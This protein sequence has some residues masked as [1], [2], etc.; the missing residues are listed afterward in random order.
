MPF[1]INTFKIRATSALI[2]GIIMLAALLAGPSLFFVIF[3]AITFLCAKEY[4]TIM[5]T[6]SK[7]NLSDSVQLI[8]AIGAAIFF[9]AIAQSGKF[10]F[11]TQINIAVNENIFLGITLLLILYWMAMM[12][13]GKMILPLI[14]GYLYIS[15]SFGLLALAYTKFN[16]LPLYLIVLIWVNDTMQY[17]VGSL[18][19]KTKMAPII[20]PK[21]TWEGTIGGSLLSITAAIVWGY[22]S[23]NYPLPLWIGLGIIASAI[24]T[25][26]DLFESKLKRTA[27]IKDSGNIMPGHGGALD[28]FDSLLLAGPFAYLLSLLFK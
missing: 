12:R 4:Y 10:S 14:S 27:G 21:K 22:F 6:I 2:F 5:H 1:D 25:L 19:G 20:S 23:K 16:M 24:G 13:N 17:I 11:I 3:A 7:Q 15:L 8:Y 26:G 28:R 18:I 9:M